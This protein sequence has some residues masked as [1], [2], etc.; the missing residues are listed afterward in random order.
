MKKSK[1]KGTE[2]GKKSSKSPAKPARYVNNLLHLHKLQ[3]T[4]LERLRQELG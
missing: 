1:E 4:L 2:Q 3:G